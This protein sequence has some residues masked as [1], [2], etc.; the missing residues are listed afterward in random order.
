MPEQRPDRDDPTPETG[1]E[2]QPEPGT[3][4]GTTTGRA[5]MRVA[6]TRPS[7]RQ[8]VVAV[9]LA[10][11]GFA[12][13]VQVRDTAANDTYEGLRE[14][15]LIEVLDGL[16]GT[17]ER[18]RREVDRLEARRDELTDENQARSAALAEAEQRVRTLNIIAGLVPV[19]GP[20]LRVT[21][22]ESDS[23][24]NVGSLLD[25][26]QE[27]RTAGAE[28][29]EFNDSVRL[30]ADSSFENAVGGIEL[31][32]ELLEP[33][34]V[35]DVI[36]DPHVLRT[37]LTF[38]TGPIETLETYDGASVEVAEDETIEIAS[39]RPATRPEYAEFG[40]GQ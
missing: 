2:A 3:T 34:Y 36:G 13:V 30:G 11:L 15:E 12:F 33:P 28:A 9:L 1:T 17:A 14:G 8:G 23:R 21:I 39:V 35:I 18:A 19:A 22:T 6:L 4:T 20:G 40:T 10:V 38:S 29:I 31:D 37:A 7:R 26:V 16:T 5:R 24:V 27:L 25:T 32:G